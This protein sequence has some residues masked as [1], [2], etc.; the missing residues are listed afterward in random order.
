MELKLTRIDFDADIYDVRKAIQEVLHGPEFYDPNDRENKGR[1]PNFQVVMGKSPAG[2]VHNREAALRL[3]TNLGPRLL[4]WYRDSEKHRIVVNGRP[5]RLFR[6]DN[7]V[8]TDVKQVLEK[9]LYVDPDKDKLR[10][11]REDGAH[12][13]RLRIA[14]VQFGIWYKASNAPGTRRSFSVEHERD[15]LN[16]S[17]AY[18]FM[19]Y[20]HK[21]IRIDVRATLLLV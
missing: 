8:P 10:T 6:T 19:E 2:R 13:I 4:R 21:L 20:E 5:L 18:L 16:H 9:A 11:Q 1:K 15:F 14:I 17:A 3:P 12:S 7:H